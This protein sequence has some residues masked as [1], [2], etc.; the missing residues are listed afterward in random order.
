MRGIQDLE[1]PDDVRYAEDHEWAKPAGDRIR[2]GISDFAQD[3]LGDI[4]YVE[5]PEVGDAFEK[6]QEFGTVESTKAVSDL[7][8]PVGGEVVAVNAVLEDSP[9]LV[10]RD[11]YRDG[12]MI[13][14]LPANPDEMDSLMNRDVYLEKL[15]NLEE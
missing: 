6:D 4:T 8:M 15:K 11:P 2:V 1:F 5:L 13:E 12:W 3:Q 9:D 14:V 10:N 7:K